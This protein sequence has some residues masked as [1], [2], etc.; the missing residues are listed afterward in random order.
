MSTANIR[1]FARWVYHRLPLS[2]RGKWRLRERLQPLLTAVMS[3]KPTA[4]SLAQAIVASCSGT[5]PAEAVRDDGREHALARMLARMAQH[6]AE[7]GPLRHWIALPF[8][9]TGGA[10]RVA[11]NLCRG[12]RGHRPDESVLL[13]LTDRKLVDPRMEIPPEL[14]VL[15]LDDYLAGDLSYARKQALLRDLLIAARPASFHNIN[16]EVAW[17]LIL[18]EGRRLQSCTRLFASIFAF[19]FTPDGRKKIGYAA[20]FL[21]PGMPYLCGLMSDNRRF[22]DDAA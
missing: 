18:E 9:A 10:E 2:Q 3:D 12:V 15:S 19:Q 8:L 21:K 4:V 22:L 17:H 13:L 7:H 6:A 5:T 11:L 16:S 14:L 1:S 20:A